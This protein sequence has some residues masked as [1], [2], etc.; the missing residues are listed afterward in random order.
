ISCPFT[1]A[2]ARG[3]CQGQE[4]NERRSEEGRS[5]P[6]PRTFLV[7]SLGTHPTACHPDARLAEDIMEE[8]EVVADE[9]QE[10]RSSQELEEKMVEEQDRPGGLNER[11]ALDALQA[12]AALKVELSSECE[13][14]LRA[15][16]QSMHK[17]HQRR[18][19]HLARR[20]AIIQGIPGFWAKAL[21]FPHPQ[22]SIMISDQE[23]DFLGYMIDLKVQVRSHPWSRYKLIFSF[24]D[25]PYFL[26]MVIIKEYYLETTGCRARHSTLVH[27]FW[28]FLRGAP[29]HSR[30]TRGLNFL[31]WLS[32]LNGP[33]SNRSAELIGKDVW[34]DRLKYYLRE[35]GSSMRD[36]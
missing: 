13:Q 35:E 18:K 12:L 23:Q 32:G 30:D 17:N 19:R 11:Q 10:Q 15:Y 20:S 7:V 33:E 5:V 16:V 14:N 2:P 28:D 29:S 36:N 21:S 22:V 1:S 34:D 26:N 25:N 6:R 8:L 4:E 27:W 31:N 9:E 3:H 24:R